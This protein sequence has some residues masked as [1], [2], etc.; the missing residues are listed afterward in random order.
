M[1]ESDSNPDSTSNSLSHLFSDEEQN[2]EHEREYFRIFFPD[3][4]AV[5]ETDPALTVS[6]NTFSIF[7]EN[8]FEEELVQYAMNESMSTYSK[9]LFRKQESLQLSLPPIRMT[10]SLLQ[11]LLKVEEKQC[12]I[13]LENFAMNDQVANIV[14]HHTFHYHCLKELVSHQHKVCPCCRHPLPITETQENECGHQ[15]TI[16]LSSSS[17]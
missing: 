15:I 8:F 14:C 7:L 10:E 1:S 11:E 3:S 12:R 17:C 4:D 5:V 16:D 2:N 9:E 13:C 6:S